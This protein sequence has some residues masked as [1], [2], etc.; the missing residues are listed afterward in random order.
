MTKNA[1]VLQ[2]KPTLKTRFA[3]ALVISTG[4]ALAMHASAAS[5]LDT[6]GLTGEIDGAKA[7][8]IALFGAAIVILG[9]FMGWKYLKRGAN[10]A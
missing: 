3:Q 1:I 2:K 8:I 4:T 7:S 10:S 6:T 9:V 5:S